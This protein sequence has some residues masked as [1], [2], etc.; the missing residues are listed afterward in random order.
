MVGKYIKRE[1][2]KRKE[3][4]TRANEPQSGAKEGVYKIWMTSISHPQELG[5]MDQ[6]QAEGALSRLLGF[7]RK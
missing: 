1:T 3:D 5:Q 6:T 2:S 4:E 7:C